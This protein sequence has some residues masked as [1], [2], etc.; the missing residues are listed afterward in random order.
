MRLSKRISGIAPSATLAVTA[1]AKKMKKEGIDVVSFGAGEPDFDTSPNAKEGGIEAIR[2]GFT[3]YTPDKGILELREAICEDLAKRGH[4]YKSEEI[5]VSSGAKQSLFNATQAL[6]ERG[7]EVVLFTPYWV[8]YVEQVRYAGAK[9]IFI[10]CSS[11]REF[12]PDVDDVRK[13]ITRKTRLIIVNSP[14][15]PT[16]A[17]FSRKTLEGIAEIALEKKISMISDEIYDRVVYDGVAESIVV[18]EPKLREESIVV[19]GVSKTYSMTGWRIGYT[20]SPLEVANAMANLQSHSTSAPSSISQKAALAAI[21]KDGEFPI[22]MVEEFRKRRD[23]IVKR[24]N[25]MGLP[26]FK[27]KGAFYV[28]PSIA[29]LGMGSSRFAELLLEKA[30]VAVVPGIAFGA[31][32]HVRLSFAT[33]ME[34]IEKGMNRM[35]DFLRGL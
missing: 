4:I 25:D 15:N 33:S 17:I 3:K 34:E 27:P 35:E 7:D 26:C 24:L 13:A 23:Y 14:C 19:N 30:R 32:D 16:G 18:L 29:H 1:K 21:R 2:S 9:P 8:T 6:L 5:V 31:D 10:K 12:E 11:D 20:A 22:K 28:F